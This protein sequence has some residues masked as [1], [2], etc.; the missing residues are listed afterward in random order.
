MGQTVVVEEE[1]LAEEE[2]YAEWHAGVLSADS[3]AERAM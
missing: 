1:A 3:P 2:V